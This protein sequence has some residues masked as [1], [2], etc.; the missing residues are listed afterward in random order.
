MDRLA[1]IIRTASQIPVFVSCAALFFLMTMTF[2]DVILRSTIN[3]PIEA[4]TELTR[5]SIAVV[6]FAAVPVLSMNGAHI[7][8]DLIDPLFSKMGWLRV[9]DA[10]IALICGVMLWWPANRVI[11][12]AERSR[13]FGDT[14]EYLNLP[15]FY[16]SWFIAL[17][18]F[19]TMGALLLRGIVLLVAP[20]YLEP[21]Q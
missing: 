10:V 5:M 3:A 13:S 6:V 2:F 8:V 16:I 20:K 15:V 19:L 11:A 14:T 17:M 4:A 9:R 12:L 7:S 21:Q 18:T 1:T